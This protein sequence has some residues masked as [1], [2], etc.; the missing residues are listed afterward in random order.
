[1][2]GVFLHL[3][4]KEVRQKLI[5]QPVTDATIDDRLCQIR[6]RDRSLY[7]SLYPE[8]PAA[9]LD[10]SRKNGK[11]LRNWAD[12]LRGFEVKDV[13][14]PGFEPVFILLLERAGIAGT[15]T[16]RLAV[17]LHRPAPN[18]C[19]HSGE[20]QQRLY[21]RLLTVKPKRPL[22]E[23]RDEH[24]Q[25]P[26][27]E[28]M[29]VAEYDGFDRALAAEMTI[30]RLQRLKDI[31]AGAACRPRLVSYAPLRISLFTDD[32]IKEYASFNE[33]LVDAVHS[34]YRQ[35]GQATVETKK[36][37]TICKLR[38]TVEKLKAESGDDKHIEEQ[39]VFGEL[40]LGNIGHIGK[41]ENLV[42]LFDPYTQKDV[43]IKLDPAKTPQQNAL[44]YFKEYKR[45]KRGRP[46]VLQRIKDLEKKIG[47]LER[48][49]A[50]EPEK[51]RPQAVKAKPQKAKPYRE[52]VL[53]S[54]S[55]V[56]VG[57]SSRGNDELTF[58][59]ARPDDYFFHVR[60]FEGS[61]ALLKA[62]LPR[63]QKPSHDDLYAAAAIAAYYS[64]A[65][66]QNKVPVSY[67]CR[68]YIKKNKKGKPGSV[69][70]MREEVIFVNP[71][72]PGVTP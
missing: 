28:K 70:M 25:P 14:Q 46:K 13:D 19:L 24:L 23:V 54:G 6:L 5:G 52:F 37:D 30:D 36:R 39:R 41:G 20:S 1:M 63:G 68:K 27:F 38:R 22:S 58:A 40:V 45:L 29:L 35:R 50:A 10:E 59:V 43:C 48:S 33:L 31:L 34:Y 9:C 42:T 61:H 18:L 55:L 66:N 44:G 4:L 49:V 64:K 26:G 11:P 3:W 21:P 12:E 53:S 8:V 65:R 47:H 67:A 57:K 15:E 17:Y 7:L 16:L 56:Y 32:F 60:G 71:A 62:R 69:I 2:N 51:P 72:L